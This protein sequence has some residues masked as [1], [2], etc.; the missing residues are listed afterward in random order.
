[1]QF[2]HKNAALIG[3]EALL[4]N[5]KELPLLPTPV[6]QSSDDHAGN[7][8]H[9]GRLAGEVSQQHEKSDAGAG[10]QQHSRADNMQVLEG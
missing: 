9:D 2:A 4:R 3:L 10:T 6:S 8:C 7:G 1:M 5:Y